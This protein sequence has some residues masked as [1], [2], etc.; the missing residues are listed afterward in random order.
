MR[1][2][3]EQGDLVTFITTEFYTQVIDF[4]RVECLNLTQ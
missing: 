3:P 2:T 4:E 1:S